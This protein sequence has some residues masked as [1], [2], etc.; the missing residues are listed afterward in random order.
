VLFLGIDVG[1]S[2]VKL[3][4][5]DGDTGK[6]VVSGQYPETELAIESRAPGWA[7]QDPEVWW[8]SFVNGSRRLFASVD[9]KRVRGIGISYQMHGLVAV[10]R[11]LHTVRPAIIWCDSRAVDCGQQAFTELGPDYCFQRLLNSPGNFTAAKLRWVQRHEPDTFARIHKAMLPGDYIAMRL[12]GEVTTTASGLSEGALWDFETRSVANQLL[13]HWQIDS[14]LVPR[15]V[16][17]VGVQGEVS[18]AAAAELGLSA[19]TPIAYRFGDQPNNAFS[20]RVLEPGEVATTAGTSGVIY[21]VT[22]QRAVDRASRVNT[23]L[24]V[25]DTVEAPRNGVLMCVNGTGRA[26]SWLRQLLASGTDGRGGTY[27]HLNRLAAS[28]P[29]GSDGLIC[30]PFGNGAER[31]FQNRNPGAQILDLDL[32]RH[33]LGHV[34][35]ATQE[36]IVFALNR[37]FEILKSLIGECRIVRAGNGNMFRSEVFTEA[38]ANTTGTVLE[39]YETDG[40]EGAARGA[41]LGVRHFGS[42]AEAFSGLKRRAVVEPAPGLADRYQAAYRRWSERLPL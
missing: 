10:D 27:E 15:I 24:H 20:L 17:G 40:S 39:L 12:S 4:L 35:R 13:Q 19:G 6:R 9:P 36:G 30:H 34:A 42:P 11:Q 5:L 38:F 8:D 41:A 22:D 31:I 23:F 18:S 33:G 37:G 28:V 25:T 21:G 29:V 1:S 7:E 26:Y 3:S 14:S 2:S 32:N 16:P